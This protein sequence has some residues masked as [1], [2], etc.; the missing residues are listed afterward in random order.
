MRDT[1]PTYEKMSKTEKGPAYYPGEVVHGAKGADNKSE[2]P[3]AG[4]I[5]MP[6]PNSGSMGAAM[7]GSG[8]PPANGIP[9]GMSGNNGNPMPPGPAVD[10]MMSADAGRG[11]PPGPECG[12]H[13]VGNPGELPPGV[14]VGETPK[15]PRGGC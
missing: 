11:L 13:D 9:L 10:P 7:T 2:S 4:S 6:P 8:L 3:G 14:P 5:N 15:E 12:G 1:D